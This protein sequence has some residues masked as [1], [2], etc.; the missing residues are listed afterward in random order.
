MDRVTCSEHGPEIVYH[1]YK[2]DPD[3]YLRMPVEQET[4]W[5]FAPDVCAWQQP[6]DLM[7]YSGAGAVPWLS[8]VMQS[9]AVKL[10][11]SGQMYGMVQKVIIN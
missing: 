9:L 7:C 2:S 8:T 10:C 3:G 5:A 6:S 4:S 1:L 11:E